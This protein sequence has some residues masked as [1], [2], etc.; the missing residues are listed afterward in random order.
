MLSGMLSV[1]EDTARIE[2][3]YRTATHEHA[4]LKNIPAEKLKT[5][6]ATELRRIDTFEESALK[7]VKGDIVITPET[8]RTI[9]AVWAIA[10]TGTYREPVTIV[11]NPL[12][13]DKPWATWMDKQRIDRAV[14]LINEV[15]LA[16]GTPLKDLPQSIAKNGPY[17]IYNGYN[18]QNSVLENV[19]AQDK[20]LPKQKVKI[21]SGDLKI[22][23]DQIKSFTLPNDP[24]LKGKAIAI[25]SHAPHLSR[26][27]H[28]VERHKP[29]PSDA[30]VLLFPLPTPE[31]GRDEF[32][33]MEIKGLLYY[34]FVAGDASE[35]VY[36]YT[37]FP[38]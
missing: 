24:D 38:L 2:A 19:I 25:V 23:V 34:M 16:R 10:G 33:F 28:M 15:A 17:L 5:I 22:T 31:E 32:A 13:R 11:D 27:M 37:I 30:K 1:G 12:L 4:L 35:E 20:L 8:A 29:F 6:I 9:G 18:F 26:I 21:I 7:D 36:P 14:A 3:I